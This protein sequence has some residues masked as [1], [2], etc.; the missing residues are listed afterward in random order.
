MSAIRA[1]E[2][3]GLAAHFLHSMEENQLFNILDARVIKE[4]TK[5]EILAIAEL[6]RRCLHP[7]G[8]RRPTMKEVAVELEGIRLLEEGNFQQ[9]EGKECN[10]VEV[11][12][13]GEFSFTSE[14][15]GGDTIIQQL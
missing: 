4:G 8:K 5:E 1:A 13:S 3:R 2:G 10:I 14:S 15:R 12:E 11:D 7:N 9:D 6:S